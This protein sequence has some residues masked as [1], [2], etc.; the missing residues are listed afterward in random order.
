MPPKTLKRSAIIVTGNDQTFT[1]FPK[2]P[3]ELRLK[4]WEY[5]SDVE[6]DI[7]IGAKPISEGYRSVKVM[8]HPLEWGAEEVFKYITSSPPPSIL[9]ANQ[10]S[11]SEGLKQYSLAFGTTLKYDGIELNVKPQIYIN[12]QRDR[13]CTS[14]WLGNPDDSIS[15]WEFLLYQPIRRLAIPWGL[16]EEI[17]GCMSVESNGLSLKFWKGIEE[18]TVYDPAC[19]RNYDL[20]KNDITIVTPRK[21][22]KSKKSRKVKLSDTIFMTPKPKPMSFSYWA[23]G[24][25]T[26]AD[27]K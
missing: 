25:T 7:W 3:I 5:V 4:I 13:I 2:L 19:P 1:R 21:S 10:E 6:R 26:L 18:M 22:K 9:H 23:L 20:P 8:L 24:G 27:C 11:R 14:D 15:T 12:F 16:N 17:F